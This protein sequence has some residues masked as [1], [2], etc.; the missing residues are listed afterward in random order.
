MNNT[1]YPHQGTLVMAN[2]S[3][4]HK[5]PKYWTKPDQFYPEH[6]LKNGALI[7]DKPRMMWERECAQELH[8]L[9]CR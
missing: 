6:F 4:C 5:D 1:T 3:A 8:W 9:I 7:E 2:L